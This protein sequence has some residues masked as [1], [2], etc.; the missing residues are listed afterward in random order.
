MKK[1]TAE[2]T[3]AQTEAIFHALMTAAEKSRRIMRLAQDSDI[4]PADAAHRLN[5]II[6]ALNIELDTAAQ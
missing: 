5:Q 1:L 4:L 6:T 3:T 2:I